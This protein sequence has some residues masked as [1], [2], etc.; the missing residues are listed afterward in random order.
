M[1]GPAESI[2]S[3]FDDM[4]R[5]FVS[6][7]LQVCDRKCEIFNATDTNQQVF[8]LPTTTDS[9]Q[10]LGTPFGKPEYITS[11]SMA[12]AES[13]KDLCDAIVSLNDPQ[14]SALLLRHCHCP[15][16]TH[17]ARTL[18]PSLLAPAANMH[19]SLTKSS[20]CA[21][22]GLQA[23]TEEQ[24]L[25]CTLPICRGG[26][27][28][29]SVLDLSPPA[30][31][32][33][34]AHTMSQLHARLSSA[35]EK[36]TQ[37]LTSCIPGSIGDNLKSA[38]D[39]L[40]SLSDSDPSMDVVEK[41]TEMSKNPAKLQHR[42]VT[43][44]HESAVTTAI[45]HACSKLSAARLHSLQGRGAGA[46]IDAIPSCGKLSMKPS[47]Y[48]LA[49]YIRLGMSMPFHSL[50]TTC[51][52]GRSLD[53]EGFHLLTCKHGGGPVRMH[54]AVVAGWSDCFRDLDLHH[55]LEPRDRYVNTEDRP[56]ITVF[57]SQS[58]STVELD[59]S[60]AHPH[61]CDIIT[62]AAKQEGDAAEY[63]EKKKKAKYDKEHLANGRSSSCIP[64]V[65]ERFGHWGGKASEYL[66]ALAGLSRDDEGRKN[67]AEFRGLWRK[68][69]SV[70]IQTW[71]TRVILNKTK[72][73]SFESSCSNAIFS[74][75]KD[76]QNAI[77]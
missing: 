15:K 3:A 36:I 67:P 2:F 64:I 5:S 11:T 20:F 25:Q 4:K 68:R 22:I 6:I 17:L 32:A 53:S 9:I 26:F 55:K 1:L 58:G 39:C 77:H 66:N 45:D 35:E 33:G 46:W 19:D 8:S 62:R 56:D 72:K 38:C 75:D 24:W 29:S 30:F 40:I 31:V 42:L 28:L 57:D 16:L 65:F 60:M 61:S 48:R 23:I 43:K 12:I 69:F 37:L 73:L 13:G 14:C 54:N 59:I 27:G 76:I 52:C 74:N 49:T 21:L 34:W 44:I 50:I 63:R 70:L 41:M 18:P 47:E 7:E 10:I 51:E 71:N